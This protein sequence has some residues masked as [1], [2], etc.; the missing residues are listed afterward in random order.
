MSS[1]AYGIICLFWLAMC[2]SSCGNV[3]PS[4]SYDYSQGQE[5]HRV[6]SSEQSPSKAC[7]APASL[8]PSYDQNFVPEGFQ[9]VAL[10]EEPN[11]A[12]CDVIFRT[13]G[14]SLRDVKIARLDVNGDGQLDMA[15]IVD[16]TLFSWG[17]EIAELRVLVSSEDS[18]TAILVGNGTTLLGGNAEAPERIYNKRN[19]N[20]GWL[21][22]CYNGIVYEYQYAKE[23]PG[24]GNYIQTA[25]FDYD[26]VPNGFQ[27]IPFSEGPD[28]GQRSI[29]NEVFCKDLQAIRDAKGNNM[30]EFDVNIG[31]LDANGDNSDDLVL[32]FYDAYFQGIHSD[33]A[34]YIIVCGDTYSA[35]NVGIGT[36]W[37]GHTEVSAWIH[38]KRNE[39]TGW[40]DFYFNGAVYEYCFAYGYNYANGYYS[41]TDRY[42]YP[43]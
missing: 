27:A 13:F 7:G 3:Y 38:C 33:G 10:D 40:L 17:P 21:D 23:N 36:L 8:P 14:D 28:A 24:I 2:L 6:Y 5:S 39:E 15:L 37:P 26:Y 18:Y 42:F 12:Q 30:Y 16:E 1:K 9:V 4:S 19:E 32:I 35:I 31:L 34:L 29:I 25:P 41:E 43:R 22:F 11:D 20:T